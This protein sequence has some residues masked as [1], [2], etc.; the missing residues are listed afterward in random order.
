MMK[1]TVNLDDPAAV[2]RW[3]MET[4]KPEG[5]RT[6]YATYS[7]MTS[8]SRRLFIHVMPGSGY[9][10]R[11]NQQWARV[12]LRKNADIDAVMAELA[13]WLPYVRETDGYKHVAILEH[14]LSEYGM[15]ELREYDQADI[16]LIKTTYGRESIESSFLSWPAALAFVRDNHWYRDDEEE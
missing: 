3:W 10:R 9:D 12:G 11:S 2:A 8:A 14:T 15:Y 5:G 13:L 7:D 6:P 1:K 16:R 4:Y